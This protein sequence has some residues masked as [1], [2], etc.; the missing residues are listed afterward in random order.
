[1][2][3]SE[4]PENGNDHALSEVLDR[5][6]EAVRDKETRIADIIE[7]LGRRSF[8]A[9]MLIPALLA[10]SPLSGIPGVTVTVGLIVATTAAQMLWGRDSLWL[11]EKLTRRA[12]PTDRL[13]KAI[14]WLRPPL[15]FIE[16]FLRPR[17][18]FLFRRPFRWITLTLVFLIGISM[19]ALEFI[20]TSGSIA[21]AVISIF[22]IG[23]LTR[24][25]ALVILGYA[26]TIGAPFL[27]W[28]LAA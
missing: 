25:G 22:S 18:T 27:V 5:L 8:P 17:L 1:M 6:E 24:D 3:A 16:R 13:C 7:G 2:N 20:P 15:K 26:L 23:L 14:G 10:V 11:P 28:Q 12:I 9:I 4:T 19:P 21:A